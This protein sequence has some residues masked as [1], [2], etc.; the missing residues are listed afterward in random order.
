MNKI[1][2]IIKREYTTRVR[3]KSFLL[4][5]LLLP[6]LYLGMTFFSGYLSA[7]SKNELKLAVVDASGKFTDDL[8]QKANA[9]FPDNQ[10]K[11]VF[12]DSAGIA[13]TYVSKGFDGYV[14]IPNSIE[15]A[16]NIMLHTKKVLGS[17]SSVEQQINMIWNDIKYKE[18]G[19]DQEK[20]A[21]LNEHIS[22]KTVSSDNEKADGKVANIIGYFTAFLMYFIILV[23]GSQVMMG[24]MEEKTNR[25]AEVIVSSVKPFQLMLGKILG[26][27]LVAITQFLLWI[28][29]I[30]VIYNVT[31]K[32][33]GDLSAIGGIMGNIGEVL[34]GINIPLII[35]LFLFYFLGGFFLYAALYAAIG[36]AVNEDLRE[37]QS[38]SFPV[39]MLV[40][41]SILMLSPAINNPSGSIAVW[42]SIIPIT[43]PIVMMARI[44]FGIPSTVPYWQLGLSMLSL[45]VG[46]VALTWF[47]GKIYRTGILMYG[48]KPTWSEM[49]KWVFKKQ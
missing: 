36:S 12:E 11:K 34:A 3:K 45:V 35:G 1:F 41:I 18:L 23:Y 7:N 31:S 28:I 8:M 26:I 30:V 27:A 46:F 39:T 48:K 9:S 33:S 37:A 43:S 25:I 44:P 17:A 2:L 29:L 20:M 32:M 47:A 4:T 40:V 6:V 42:G 15:A 19:I 16:N 49:L 14:F 10:L 22:I 13:A 21:K 38:L 5:T 24:V